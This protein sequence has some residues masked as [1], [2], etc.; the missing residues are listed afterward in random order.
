MPGGTKYSLYS[1][2]KKSLYI[3]TFYAE[4]FLPVLTKEAEDEISVYV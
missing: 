1:V 4:P 3:V 2:G